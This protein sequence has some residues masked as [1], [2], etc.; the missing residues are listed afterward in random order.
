MKKYLFERECIKCGDM[1]A[2]KDEFQEAFI[3]QGTLMLPERIKRT[4]NN[5]GYTW[6]ELPLDSE[7]MQ[8]KEAA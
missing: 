5:C 8:K 6:D 1:D 7:A 2:K 4:C 3:L